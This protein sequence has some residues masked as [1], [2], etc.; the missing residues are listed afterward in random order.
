MAQAL[1]EISCMIAIQAEQPDLCVHKDGPDE[2]RQVRPDAAVQNPGFRY[3]DGEVEINRAI[4]KILDTART[5]ILTAQPDGPRPGPV[6]DDALS[7]VRNRIAAGISMRTL[8]QHSTRFDEPT[9]EYVQS[10]TQYGVQVR[11]LAEFFDRM[12]LVDR[13]AAFIPAN[14][15]R[16]RAV[17]VTEPAVVHFLA[18]VFDR[19]W[20]RAAPFPFLPVRAADAAPEVIPAIRESIRKL[21]VEGR[22]DKEIARRLG[23]SLRSLQ[24][25]VAW[26]KKEYG[27]QH[28][29]QL[30]YLMGLR[31][32]AAGALVER[33]P[34]KDGLAAAQAAS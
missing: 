19:A 10:V 29:L 33:L 32:Q 24:A 4:Q 7:A 9:K 15:D 11:T 27:A 18:D 13:S 3:L 21:L 31:G 2:Y 30:G 14:A 34:S 5:E 1:S 25:H 28:R 8:Y 16:S 17:L 6:L 12:I 22:S 23:L 26:L 20:D